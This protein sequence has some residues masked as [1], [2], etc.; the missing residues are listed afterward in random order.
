MAEVGHLH[1][2]GC[3]KEVGVEPTAFVRTL[4]SR[5]RIDSAAHSPKKGSPGKPSRRQSD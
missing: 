5:E 2:Q 1:F 3:E 4:A